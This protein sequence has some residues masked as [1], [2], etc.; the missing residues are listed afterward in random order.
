MKSILLTTLLL[1]S[2]FVYSQP[3]TIDHTFGNN[4]R[5]LMPG[6]EDGTLNVAFSTAIQPD[7]KI[8]TAGAGYIGIQ[9]FAVTRNLSNGMPDPSFNDDGIIFITTITRSSDTHSEA[10]G[11]TVAP[12]GKIIVVGE[13]ADFVNRIP[14]YYSIVVR[15]NSDGTL[16]QTFSGDGIARLKLSDQ[17]VSE[18]LWGVAVQP[19]GKI[20]ASGTSRK[21]TFSENQTM[22]L[23]RLNTD[24]SL[25][26]EFGTGGIARFDA[27]HISNGTRL[28]IQP[29][30]KITAVG[31]YFQ[32]DEYDALVTRFNHNGT[33]DNSFDNDGFRV[34]DIGAD[35][36][37]EDVE[38]ADNGKV[39][40]AGYAYS[41]EGVNIDFTVAKF[42]NNGSPDNQFD[43]DGQKLIDQSPEDFAHALTIDHEHRILLTGHSYEFDAALNTLTNFI[44]IIRL[45]E[46]GTIDTEFAG[47]GSY[48][49][50]FGNSA[51]GY[52]AALQTDGR[53]V[54][55]GFAN[56]GENSGRALTRINT[57][58]CE[59]QITGTFTEVLV[60]PAGVEN[61]TL[62]IGYTPASASSLEF[63][64]TGNATGYT[65]N[66]SSLNQNASFIVD[67][68][69]PASVN[70]SAGAEGS[71]TFTLTIHDDKGCEESF[72]KNI[73][74]D[75][76]RCGN[77][78][79]KVLVCHVNKNDPSKIKTICV[80]PNAV[81]TFLDN[82]SHLGPCTSNNSSR[83]ITD[84]VTPHFVINNPTQ[85]EFTLRTNNITGSFRL[86]VMDV[87]GRVIE[88]KAIQGSGPLQFGGRYP[89][90]IYLAI[91]VHN[92]ESTVIKLV[93]N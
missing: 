20:V 35:N 2:A 70:I 3:G 39:T 64:P 61:N 86:N 16:D 46:N 76:V 66:W 34:T 42:L 13:T 18:R 60:L 55:A 1:V 19:D 25:D 9:V 89:K 24:G 10:Y 7:G 44:K 75:D 15:L 31:N 50:H 93:K 38:V 14:E 37:W 90:G 40:V 33:L 27:T 63:V 91:V 79:N 22:T 67:P 26:N 87:L 12:D 4:G 80:S 72:S 88:T 82:G 8:V 41:T 5:V 84:V 65:Y 53:L 74:I 58:G 83:S 68:S 78:M 77:N 28:D 23:V 57:A 48:E 56:D 71:A 92:G 52:D 85:H 73:I 43:G 54:V 81:Q 51:I 69:N 49:D 36:I 17:Y 59:G 62:Y 45:L 29:N 32:N 6:A 30:G 21:L 47:D 11:I